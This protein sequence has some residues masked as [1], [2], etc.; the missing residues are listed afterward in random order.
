MMRRNI[1]P[2]VAAAAALLG[3]GW[4]LGRHGAAPPAPAPRDGVAVVVAAG[5]ADARAPRAGA[6]VAASPS[7]SAGNTPAPLSEDADVKGALPDP[8]MEPAALYRRIR[9]EPV[10]AA[11]AGTSQRVIDAALVKV[12]YLDRDALRVRCATT[13]CEVHGRTMRDVS[14][15]NANVAIQALQGDAVRNTL[16]GAGMEIVVASFGRRGSRSIRSGIELAARN[17]SSC[18]RICMST[19]LLICGSWS[20]PF[21]SPPT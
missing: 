12:P 15:E 7:P 13:L 10:D 19:R 20:A 14:V 16:G 5:P 2:G 6:P 11:L 9:A 3:A 4:L 17:M 8:L 18:R 1:L 21:P